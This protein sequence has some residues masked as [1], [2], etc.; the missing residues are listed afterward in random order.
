MGG[1]WRGVCRWNYS[2][3]RAF[4]RVRERGEQGQGAKSGVATSMLGAGKNQ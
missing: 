2:G 4:G 1:A 3:G